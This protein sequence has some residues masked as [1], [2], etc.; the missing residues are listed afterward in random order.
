MKRGQI[1]DVCPLLLAPPYELN[2]TSIINFPLLCI[3]SDI[4]KQFR[5]A[6]QAHSGR[7]KETW[8]MYHPFPMIAEYITV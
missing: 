1:G 2:Q 5:D 7:V 8:G 4:Q 6:Q 3:E